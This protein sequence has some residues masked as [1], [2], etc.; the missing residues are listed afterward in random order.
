MST[1]PRNVLPQALADALR[2]LSEHTGIQA[3]PL[4][5]ALMLAAADELGRAQ[6][7]RRALERSGE[8]IDGL[9]AQVTTLRER[10]P[11]WDEGGTL[12]RFTV[13]FR[14]P[15]LNVAITMKDGSVARYVRH[16]TKEQDHE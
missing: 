1:T 15:P 5:R 12:C 9:R 4:A 11:V 13:P 16:T 7:D 8:R 10:V 2:S 3:V 14:I 6:A